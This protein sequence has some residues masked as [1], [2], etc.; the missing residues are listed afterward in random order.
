MFDPE[1]LKRFRYLCWT[2]QRARGRGL[3]APRET[4]WSAGTAAIGLRDYAPGD[5]YRQIDWTVC[6][7]RDELLTRVVATDVDR[8]V[9]VLLDCSRSMGTGRPAKF[10]L[11]R[12]IAA[13]LGYAAL[14]EGARL[15]VVAFAD[16]IVAELPAVRH[17]NRVP[18][19][20]RF[21]DQLELQGE[22]TDLTR[23][24]DVFVRRCQRHGPTVVIGDLLDPDGFQR[25]FDVLRGRG[26]D[27]RLVQIH[28]PHE[29]DPQLLGDVELVDVEA[30]TGR[31]A[32][33]TERAVQ[34]YRA[35]YAEFQT[36]VGR[37]CSRHGITR[38]PVACDATEEAVLLGVLGVKQQETRM[39]NLRA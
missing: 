7:R 14:T 28:D 2:A 19:L 30:R 35:L 5:D 11:A 3:L 23:A 34:R 31:R 29:A 22:R 12:R 27:V 17:E 1:L 26:Y 33:V 8:D 32:T 36:S 13:V 4:R 15:N 25:G 37:Y 21:L 24:A 10:Q 20:L 6:A 38:V 18:K 16:G 39:S 9:Y